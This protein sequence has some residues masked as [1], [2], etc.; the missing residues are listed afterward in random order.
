MGKSWPGLRKEEDSGLDRD[1]GWRRRRA[2]KSG[3]IRPNRRRLVFLFG[4]QRNASW[5]RGEEREKRRETKKKKSRRQEL[6]GW[7]Q[8]AGQEEFHSALDP[9]GLR[10]G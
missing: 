3:R 10:M 7:R 1:E 9:R 8:Q 5:S 2:V 4:S 6:T